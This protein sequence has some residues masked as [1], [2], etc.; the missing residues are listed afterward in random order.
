MR[1]FRL[2]MSQ[3]SP[4]NWRHLVSVRRKRETKSCETRKPL[5]RNRIIAREMDTGV[6][7]G[8]SFSARLLPLICDCETPAYPPGLDVHSAYPLF[9]FVLGPKEER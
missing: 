1:L 3:H 8:A 5:A 6:R 4:R 2:E 7:E 9:D